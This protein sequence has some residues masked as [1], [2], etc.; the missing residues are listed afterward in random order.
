MKIG[1]AKVDI[2]PPLGV[3][4]CGQLEPMV[5]DGIESNLFASAI[6]LDDE[7]VCVC[8]CSCELLVFENSFANEV[9]A[10]A[11]RKC[12]LL[13]GN[14]ILTATHTHSGPNTAAV[15]GKGANTE[16][17]DSLKTRLV[18]VISSAY[19][20]RR[21]GKLL[22]GNCDCEGLAFQRRYLMSDGRVQTHP[23]KNDPHIVCAMGG[24]S[25]RLGVF[26][27]KDDAGKLMA[28]GINFGCHATV[29][30]RDNTRLS[31]DY[32][33]KAAA[34]LE[35]A[36][37]APAMFLLGACG[38]ICQVNPFDDSRC[39]VGAG[40]SDY[41]GKTLAARAGDIIERGL[42]PAKGRLKV[43]R[44]SITFRRRQID[45][46]YREW[47]NQHK[48]IPCDIPALSDYGTEQYGQMPEGKYSLEEIFTTPFWANFYANEIKTLDAAYKKCPTVEFEVT[49]SAQD[50]WAMVFVPCELFWGVAEKI[51]AASPFEFT[52]VVTL[53]G[54]WNGYI[55]T[56]DAFNYSG[57]YE[58]K[59]VTSTM[60][61]PDSDKNLIEFVSKIFRE[62]N[63]E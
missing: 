55:P 54:G 40:W 1:F 3:Y 29:M 15:F 18:D 51:I 9:S 28:A 43:L 21:P 35:K 61:E 31:S 60:L 58:T 37:N 42:T 56:S 30:E 62:M 22:F 41:M 53:G 63:K 20:S 4:L 13:C 48:N 17:L 46:R 32:P 45:N 26:A 38:D 12:G 52:F 49:I 7:D 33:G 8:I 34:F 39:E 47:A 59:E 5:A 11:A 57:G 50:N 14:I 19:E 16:Y 44:R 24:D 23:L 25:T 36:L 2:T 27:A 6:C 10:M